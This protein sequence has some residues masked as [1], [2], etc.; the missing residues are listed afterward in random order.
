MDYLFDV[1]F[2]G[3]SYGLWWR[4]F[5]WRSF[6]QYFWQSYFFS[7]IALSMMSLL[8]QQWLSLLQL[9][10]DNRATSITN[11]N[12]WTISAD[13]IIKE[14]PVVCME[15]VIKAWV[16]QISYTCRVS[17]LVLSVIEKRHISTAEIPG[18]FTPTCI[19]VNNLLC[20]ITPF[21]QTKVGRKKEVIN[22]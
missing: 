1:I 7:T 19:R 16:V 17:S 18:Y 15:A 2:S 11:N 14:E 4:T 12:P 3:P 5:P 10:Q 20:L 13:S 21:N 8:I 9:S 6:S 22:K